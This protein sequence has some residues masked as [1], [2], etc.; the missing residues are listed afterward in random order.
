MELTEDQYAERVLNEKDPILR[1]IWAVGYTHIQEDLVNFELRLIDNNSDYV[2][3]IS[4]HDFRKT[5]YSLSFKRGLMPDGSIHTWVA[6]ADGSAE[7]LRQLIR[8]YR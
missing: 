8:A 5:A 2:K 3:K 7:R 4:L 6:D 1:E